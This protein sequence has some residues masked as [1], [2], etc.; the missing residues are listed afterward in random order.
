MRMVAAV[1]NAG[2]IAIPVIVCTVAV[3]LA[4]IDT[5]FRLCVPYPQAIAADGVE[6]HG[7]IH[8]PEPF[9]VVPR[10]NQPFLDRI[11]L[12]V[13]GPFLRHVDK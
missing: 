3:P 4:A 9:H 5:R 7:I 11:R 6:E 10:C 12:G 8:A 1:R 2:A 13:G